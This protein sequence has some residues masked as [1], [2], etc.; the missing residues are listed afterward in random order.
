ML[1]TKTYKYRIYPTQKQESRMTNHMNMSRYVWNW[2]LGG[3]MKQYKDSK[4]FP[5]MIEQQNLLPKLKEEK[6]WFKNVYSM[7]LQDANRRLHK[8]LITFFK[9]K[10]EGNTDTGFP[11]YKKKGQWN[12]L[13]YTDYGRNMPSYFSTM[14]RKIGKEKANNHIPIPK[15]G[16]VKIKR[17][18]EL[19]KGAVVK[20]MSII[21]DGCKWFTCFTFQFEKAVKEVPKQDLLT[22]S[23][24]IDMGLNDFVYTSGGLSEPLPKFYRKREKHLAKVQRKLSK[25]KKRSARYYKLLKAVQKAHYRVKMQRQEFHHQVANWL[26]KHYDLIVIEDLAIKNMIRKAKPKQDEE[27]NFTRNGRKAKSGLSKSIANAGWYSFRVILENK[28]KELGKVVV[29]IAPQYTSQKC[30]GCGATV[31]KALS[32]RTHSCNECGF[33]A[34]RDHNAAINILTLGLESLGLYAYDAPTIPLG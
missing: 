7:V 21:K 6:P 12:S 3:I 16:F 23:V 17:H 31:K 30:S 2:H 24:G 26:L 20:T 5:S 29:A 9:S 14:N 28:A 11:K 13:N 1:I 15:I 22:H 10:K 8:A 19:P 34:N 33:T 18:R 32:V 4:T 27:G 25:A